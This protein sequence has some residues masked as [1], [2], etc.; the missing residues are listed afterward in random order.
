M[1]AINAYNRLNVNVSG[2]KKA[3]EKLSSGYRIN[4]A[5]DDAAG[6]AISEKMRSQIRGLGQAKRNAQDGISMIQTFEG[7]AQE[8]HSILQRMKE[9]ATESANGTYN[10]ATD[11][12]AI[13][14]EFDHL[15]K[16][17]STKAPDISDGKFEVGA[18]NN[19]D[20]VGAGKLWEQAVTT[21]KVTSL[22]NSDTIN[23]KYSV[24]ELDTDGTVKNGRANMLMPTAKSLA[25]IAVQLTQLRTVVLVMM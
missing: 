13:Q 17:Y 19:K 21:D 4:C 2:M 16:D 1:N 22:K 8:T 10:N 9:L 23:T 7:T 15:N 25:I 6:L 18:P 5:G 11:R 12:A 3:S 20:V 24:A 14:L